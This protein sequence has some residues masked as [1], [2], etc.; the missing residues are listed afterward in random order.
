MV[1]S[2]QRANEN[3]ALIICTAFHLGF[4][5]CGRWGSGI[6]VARLPDGSWSAPSAIAFAGLGCGGLVGFELTDF[7]YV[8]YNDRDVA[9]IMESATFTLGLNISCAVGPFGRTAE[10]SVLMGSRG[11]AT[12]HSFSKTRGL[13]GGVSLEGGVLCELPCTNKKVYERNLKAKQLLSGD[14]PPPPEADSLMRI[15]NSDK[16][17]REPSNAASR[18]IGLSSPRDQLHYDH[19][20][21]SEQGISEL[22]SAQPAAQEVPD[23]RMQ[24]Y[25]GASHQLSG[26]T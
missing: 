15:L 12:K 11:L 25:A 16:L 23:G 19:A 1:F 6:I 9:T 7:V 8:L 21:L 4:L 26:R 22:P 5:G 17:R 20:E 2:Q 10:T 24:G 18:G 14:V 3:Q 13:Y